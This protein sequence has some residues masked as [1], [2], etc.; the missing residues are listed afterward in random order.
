[1]IKVMMGGGEITK[2]MG[3]AYFVGLMEE[4]MKGNL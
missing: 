2:C 3:S 4:Y 1:M